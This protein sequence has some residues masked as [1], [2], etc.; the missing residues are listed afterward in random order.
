[1]NFLVLAAGFTDVRPGLIFW[2]LITFFIVAFLLRRMAW[3]PIL[4]AV[5]EREKA[6]SGS[7]ESAKRERAE[8]EKLLGEQKTAIAGARA[9]AAEMMRKNQADMEKFREDLMGKSRKEAEDLKADARRS[10][11]EE[12]VKA[13]SEIKQHTVAL[14]LQVA[15]K[16]IEEKLDDAKHKALAEKFVEELGRQPRA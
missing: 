15:E 5:E 10:I 4:K 16:L 14:A 11:E 12:R 1:M 13:V 6:I 2:T 7:I 3:G 9:E 8:A